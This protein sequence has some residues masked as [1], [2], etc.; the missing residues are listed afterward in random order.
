MSTLKKNPIP[1]ASPAVAEPK[2]SVPQL[3]PPLPPKPTQPVSHSPSTQPYQPI[4]IPLNNTHLTQTPNYSNYLHPPLL[5][6]RQHSLGGIKIKINTYILG[7]FIFLFITQA[8]IGIISNIVLSLLLFSFQSSPALAKSPPSGCP[9]QP[10]FRI[11]PRAPAKQFRRQSMVNIKCAPVLYKEKKRRRDSIKNQLNATCLTN[12]HLHVDKCYVFHNISLVDF[13]LTTYDS[14]T[15][16]TL[17]L[18]PKESHNNQIIAWNI[19]R[20]TRVNS[21]SNLLPR[22]TTYI[23]FSTYGYL[24][25]IGIMTLSFEAEY[26]SH[27]L[28][29]SLRSSTLRMLKSMV[30]TSGNPKRIS[31]RTATGATKVVCLY[32]NHGF[33]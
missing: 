14:R 13:S 18:I 25:Y 4:L 32:S 8:Q 16:I 10:A 2:V 30:S 3:D 6:P 28:F 20:S 7:I 19:T 11:S 15:N 22:R 21:K 12:R 27:R 23:H 1:P 29:E 24:V 9:T 33:G 31:V 5:F 17:Y 26:R